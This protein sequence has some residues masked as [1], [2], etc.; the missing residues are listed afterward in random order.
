MRDRLIRLLQSP[1]ALLFPVPFWALVVGLLYYH[2]DQ[3]LQH[4]GFDLAMQRGEVAFQLV[5]VMRHWNSEHGGVYAPLT[6]RTPENPWLDVPEK[7]ITSPEG[8]VLTKLNPAYM[9]R[10]IAETLRGGELEIHLTSLKLMNPGNKPDDWETRALTR[11]EQSGGKS[12]V[13]I[14]GD[15]F[16]YMAPLHIEPACMYCHAKMGYQVGD[17]RGGLS[18][19]F[20]ISHAQR[21]TTNLRRDSVLIH[22]IAFLLLSVTGIA[23]LIGLR[24]LLGSLQHERDERE[25]IIVDRTSNLQQEIKR[26]R[27]SQEALSYLAHHD[28]LTGAHNRRWIL[29]RLGYLKQEAEQ[30]SGTL[31]VLMLDIDYFKHIND[32][33]G[34]QKGDEVLVTFVSRLQSELRQSDQLGRYGGE[35]FL[36][37]LPDTS[38]SDAEKIAQRLR[39]AIADTPFQINDEVLDVTTSIG[40]ACLEADVSLGQDELVGRA[41]V[42]LYL[43]KQTGRNRVVCWNDEMAH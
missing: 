35:E 23:A 21:L 6:E 30:C 42:A 25:S 14:V 13:E 37:L 41:D 22:G 16:R 27:R 1:L 3:T 11:L 38:K 32:R 2:N 26:H 17:M 24:R 40:L 36:V 4:A 10:Q 39:H 29:A 15:R 7:T 9:T 8:V 19:S 20:P 28:E 43:A 33:Y 18:V 5:Q 31:A 34:H 12:F